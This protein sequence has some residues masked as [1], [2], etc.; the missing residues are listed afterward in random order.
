LSVLLP[1]SPRVNT[2]TA[3]PRFCVPSGPLDGSRST[4]PYA[5]GVGAPD[6][7]FS[8][9]L[10]SSRAGLVLHMARAMSTT[11]TTRLPLAVST[12]STSFWSSH[13]PHPLERAQ[14]R[15]N[16]SFPCLPV[17]VCRPSSSSPMAP[18]V[19]P[20]EPWPVPE[21]SRTVVLGPWFLGSVELMGWRSV[22]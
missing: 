18:A 9:P 20:R 4:T 2:S 17:T 10:R 14:P 7:R 16:L 1:L 12:G 6:Q 22:G 5:P 19:T 13:Y 21:S 3:S 8:L 15:L 11:Q